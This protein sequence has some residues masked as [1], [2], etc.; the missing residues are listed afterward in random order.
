MS[1]Q[2]AA[3]RANFWCTARSLSSL[4]SV[5]RQLLGARLDS[6]HVSHSLTHAVF[7]QHYSLSLLADLA[8]RSPNVLLGI[9]LCL[10][11]TWILSGFSKFYLQLYHCGL[12]PYIF[13]FCTSH[14]VHSCSQILLIMT[15]ELCLSLTGTEQ[16]V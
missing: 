4:G 13:S 7:Q 2:S 8:V 12:S 11:F 3:T 14:I 9:I 1:G 16:A 5:E 15:D 6:S 10:A